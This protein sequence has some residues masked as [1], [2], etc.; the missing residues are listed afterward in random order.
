MSPRASPPLKALCRSLAGSPPLLNADD[1]CGLHPSGRIVMLC[2]G[3]RNRLNAGRWYTQCR[4]HGC[5]GTP[6]EFVWYTDR[7]PMKDLTRISEEWKICRREQSRASRLSK[8]IETKNNGESTPNDPVDGSVVTNDIILDLKAII[9][10]TQRE[11]TTAGNRT[12]AK[13][14]VLWW[15][16]GSNHLYSHDLPE[17]LMEIASISH[18]YWDPFTGVWRGPST[19]IELRRARAGEIFLFKTC[20]VASCP[21]LDIVTRYLE[22]LYNDPILAS[23]TGSSSTQRG[24]SITVPVRQFEGALRTHRGKRASTRQG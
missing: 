5:R 12:D 19:K 11:L 8:A 24:D 2:Y 10:S 14:R 16:A 18:N 20:N 9:R 7:L 22:S 13:T 21:G 23:R 15:I 1:C 3:S 4:K 6:Q 17:D